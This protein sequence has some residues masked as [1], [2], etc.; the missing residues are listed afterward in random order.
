[1][2]DDLKPFWLVWSPKGGLPSATHAT[3]E[4]ATAEAERLAAKHPD[5]PFYVLE[6]KSVSAIRPH[7]VETA[8]LR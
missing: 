7:P 5:R 4:S 2:N 6:A 1:M 8:T 3:I